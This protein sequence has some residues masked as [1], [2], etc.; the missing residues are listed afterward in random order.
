MEKRFLYLARRN[1]FC[2]IEKLIGM[3]L[4]IENITG[5]EQIPKHQ[6]NLL[7]KDKAGNNAIQRQRNQK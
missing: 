2:D 7:S 1:Y 3:K 6:L 4:P 5:F